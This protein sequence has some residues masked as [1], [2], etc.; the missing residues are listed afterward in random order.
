MNKKHGRSWSHGSKVSGSPLFSKQSL[1]FLPGWLKCTLAFLQPAGS[2][3]RP[4]TSVMAII[5]ENSAILI[6]AIPGTRT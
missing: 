5:P 6:L 1:L 2:A 3:R 4:A